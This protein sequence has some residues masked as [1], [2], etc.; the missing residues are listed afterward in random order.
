MGRGN[1]CVHGEYE[2]LYYVDWDNFIYYEENEDGEYVADREN[3]DMQRWLFEDSL[4]EFKSSMKKRFPSMRDC[5]E[6]I[7][8]CQDSRAVLENNLFY[9]TIEDNGWSMAFKLI[10]KEQDYYSLGNIANMQKGL[11]EKYLNGIRDCLFNQFAELGT[12]GGAWTSGT[13]KREDIV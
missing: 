10:Q 7:G 4:C 13:I 5:D 11:Y 12:Y 6:W 1:V 2:G 8:R 9:I 3:Y